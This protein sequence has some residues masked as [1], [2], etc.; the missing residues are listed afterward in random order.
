MFPFPVWQK[1]AFE[2]LI[3]YTFVS[4]FKLVFLIHEIF[5]TKNEVSGFNVICRTEMGLSVLL[6][7]H[8]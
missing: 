1:N 6:C 3:H 8:A 7:S 4:S 5:S 2:L